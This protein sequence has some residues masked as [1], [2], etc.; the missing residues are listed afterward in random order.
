M[1][2]KRM[3]WLAVG[4]RGGGVCDLVRGVIIVRSRRD[5]IRRACGVRRAARVEGVG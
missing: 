4:E 1:G 3:E 2:K 5:G